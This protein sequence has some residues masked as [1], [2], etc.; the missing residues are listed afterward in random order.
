MLLYVSRVF[1]ALL[2]LFHS[3]DQVKVGADL[4]T[5]SFGT[6]YDITVTIYDGCHVNQTSHLLVY[7]VDDRPQT[8]GKSALNIDESW[9][10]LIGRFILAT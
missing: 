1:L 8:P 4:I 7:V 9:D 6:P 2:V 5:A 10:D 3:V